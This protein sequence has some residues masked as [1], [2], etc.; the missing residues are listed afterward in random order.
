LLS[1]TLWPDQPL[2][3]SLT[4]TTNSLDRIARPSILQYK[5]QRYV[6]RNTIVAAAG[7]CE[8]ADV[9]R[10]SSRV[11]GKLD[12]APH[13]DR[14]GANG[15][16]GP[17]ITLQKKETSN[18]LAMGSIPVR[19]SI[20]AVQTQAVERSCWARNMSFPVF[21]VIARSTASRIPVHTS[22]SYFA[23]PGAFIISAGLDRKQ[24]PKTIG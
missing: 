7:R 15:H 17:H 3:R 24:L 12:E 9:V 22:T 18:P 20:R 14:P 16:R 13:Q 11:L 10:M 1:A 8:H 21:Q 5:R 19:D 2:G 23:A 4:G 6:C